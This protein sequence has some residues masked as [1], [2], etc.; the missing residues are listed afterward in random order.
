MKRRE[1]IAAGAAL[2]GTSVGLLSACGGSNDKPL[3]RYKVTNLVASTAGYGAPF[4]LPDFVDAWGIATRPAGAGGHFWITAG[5]KSWQFV[6][7]VKAASDAKLQSFFQDD[8]REV[9]I[10]GADSL[11]GDTSIGKSTGTVFNGAPLDSALFRVTGQTATIDGKTVQFDG[12]A[13]FV[14]VTDSGKV[15]AWTDRAKDGATVRR[16]GPTQEVF[17]GA[18][19]GMAF[20]GVALDPRTWSSLWLADFGQSPQ[21]RTLNASWQ[22]VPTKGFVNPFA[23]GERI[24]LTNA[25]L[26]K[27][28]Q[29][30]DPVPFNI[31]VI[32]D[33]AY[34]AYCISQPDP[35]D[36][37]Q[38]YAAE[39]EALDAAAEKAAGFRPDKGKLVEFDLD[40]NFIRAI[41]DGGRLNA[42]W[43]VAKAPS[44]FGKLSGALLVGNF[45]GAGLISA[46]DA[47]SGKF[48]DHLRDNRGQGDA[49]GERIA[50]EGL[51]A[52]AFGNG[53][54]LGDANALYFAAGPKDE[55]EGVFGS[56]RLNSDA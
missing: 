43:G 37:M 16:D 45:G 30:G 26:G 2:A 53:A 12:S 31:Q 47:A 28:A 44:N 21:I 24:D 5:E 48:I 17:D 22:L 15:S 3:N 51:W 18:D 1:F 36:A 13:R 42:P 29:P 27:R 56:I 33:R 46:F 9:T 55:T 10:P 35:T 52:L 38:F 4:V 23:T 34:V 39:E 50:V 11:S 14:F 32:G 54:S 6:G 20:F 8:L 40:G 49:E 41:E 19:Q 7:D 25:A